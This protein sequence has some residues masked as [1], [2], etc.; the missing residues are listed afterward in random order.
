[1]TQNH[2]DL[3]LLSI[4]NAAPLIQKGEISPVELTEAFLARIETIDK[5]VKSYITLMADTAMTEARLAESQ[6]M[7]GDY[8]GPL[9]GIP[10]ALKD[11]YDTK[12]IRTT[13]QSKVL[14]N[15]VPTK[16]A[17]AT[18]LLKEAGAIILGKLAMH[19]FALGGPQTSLFEQACNPWNLDHVTG[20][21]SSGSGAAVA[22]ALCMGALGSDTAGSI[23]GPASLCGI[24]GLKPTYGRVSRYG[25]LPLSW[26]LDHCGPMTWTVEDA[27]IILQA[28]AGYDPSDLTSSKTTVPNYSSF[29]VEDVKGLT[30]GLPRHYFFNEEYVNNETLSAVETAISDLER[31]GAKVQ[32]V[33]VP[34]L[35]YTSTAN[36]VMMVGEAF[37]YHRKNLITQ[38]ENFG[39]PVRLRF[40][41]G[42]LFSSA[43]YIQAQR[44][45]SRAKKE[46]AEVFEQVDVIACP[47]SL[48]VASSLSELDPLGTLRAPSFTAPFNQTGMPAISIPCGFSQ[49]GLPIGFQI[50]GRP[51]AESTVIQVA[52]TYQQHAKWFQ[53]RPVL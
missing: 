36:T 46:F 6:I 31:L 9:H 45:R 15:R 24:V 33:T 12:G 50:A 27:A 14:E 47:T 23:R 51:F 41:S 44:A 52:Y 16:D 1:M 5:R 21:S 4:A 17:T 40:Y 10:I 35:E 2:Q 7:Q 3:C 48:N 18:R 39:E 20:G 38:P 53:Q 25:V 8:R 42:S 49:S 30:I 43:D 37:G 13:G 34:S 32:E 19:E 29:L 11:L 28:I 22:A 26:S